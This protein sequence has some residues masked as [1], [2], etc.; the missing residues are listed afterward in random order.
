VGT[1]EDG[2][3]VLRGWVEVEETGMGVGGKWK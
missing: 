2:M 1:G 3:A